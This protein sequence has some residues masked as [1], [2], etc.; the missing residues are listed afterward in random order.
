MMSAEKSLDQAIEKAGIKK[1][2]LVR[3][4]TT[5]YGR[6]YIDSGMTALLRSPVMQKEQI[7][8]IRMYGR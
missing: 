4:V 8:L 6:A 1:E 5:G 7:I 2:D 3:I